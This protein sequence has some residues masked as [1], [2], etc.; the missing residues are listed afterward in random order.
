[1]AQELLGLDFEI[2]GGGSDLIFPHHE[3]EDAQTRSAT[4]SALAQIW[5]HNGMLRLERRE[6]VE[7]GRQRVRAR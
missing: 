2:H 7:V 4:G 6:D 1:M 3:N 5:M